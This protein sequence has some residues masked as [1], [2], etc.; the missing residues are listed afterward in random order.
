M[1]SFATGIGRVEAAT[2]TATVP[3]TGSVLPS[4]ML[5]CTVD[6]L[7]FGVEES[8][9]TLSVEPSRLALMPPSGCP[10]IL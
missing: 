6:P 4:V 8:A 1:S 10:V 9:S 7:P 5:S 2:V 3:V